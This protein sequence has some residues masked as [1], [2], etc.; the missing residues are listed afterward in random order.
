[1][2]EKADPDYTGKVFYQLVPN[3][4]EFELKWMASY[5]DEWAELDCVQLL[6][7]SAGRFDFR[8]DSI[9]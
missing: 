5:V 1:M 2:T 8:F 4:E 9:V 7:S 3:R 6:L